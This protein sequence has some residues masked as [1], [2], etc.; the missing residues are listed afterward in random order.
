MPGSSWVRIGGWVAVP[1]TLLTLGWG[2]LSR[3][4]AGSIASLPPEPSGSSPSRGGPVTFVGDSLTAQGDWQAAFPDRVVHNQGVSG[5]TS[6]QLMARLPAIRR[7]GARTYLVMVG[8]NDIV[9]GYEPGR[10]AARIQW[11]RTG[12]Q[13]GSGAR[14]IVQSTIPCARFRCGADGVRRVAELNQRLARQT[15]E[16]DYVDLTPVMADA[17]GLKRAYTVDGVHLNAAGYARWQARLRE[18][19][20]P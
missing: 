5:D 18:L 4:G 11:L 19:G 1:L 13:L 14:V 7:T 8:I 12:L 17:D 6:F 2:L 16:R 3:P 10:I 20:L 9:W 15:P